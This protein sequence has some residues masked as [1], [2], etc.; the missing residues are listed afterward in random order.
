MFSEK[1]SSPYY[2]IWT[3]LFI[4]RVDWCAVLVGYFCDWIRR[5]S[6]CVDK[7]RKENGMD[8]PGLASPI[9]AYRQ[10]LCRMRKSNDPSESEPTYLNSLGVLDLDLVCAGRVRP[11]G[12]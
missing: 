9:P 8:A 1:A 10:N 5:Y 6:V 4:F 11:K 3:V 7:D 12:I 2:T